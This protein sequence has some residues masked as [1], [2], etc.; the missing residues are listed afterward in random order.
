M[1]ESQRLD[2]DLKQRRVVIG[3][4]LLATISAEDDGVSDGAVSFVEIL[5]VYMEAI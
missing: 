3:R 1:R 4:S 2:T 5:G